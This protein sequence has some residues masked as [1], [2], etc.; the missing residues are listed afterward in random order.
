MTV[1]FTKDLGWRTGFRQLFRNECGRWWRSPAWWVH[2]L[3]WSVLLNGMTALPLWRRGMAAGVD[4]LGYYTLFAGL[5]PVIVGVIIMQNLTIGERLNGT[6]AWVL[7]KPVAPESFVLAKF[8]GAAVNLSVPMIILPSLLAG[9]QVS[10]AESSMLFSP[11]FFAGIGLLL[12]HLLFYLALTAMLGVFF[13][14]RGPVIIIPL[15]LAFIQQYLIRGIPFLGELLP[16]YLAMPHEE[17]GRSLSETLM[18][19]GELYS[20]KAV[21]STAVL[22][23]VF[24]GLAAE[25]LKHREL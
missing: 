4:P 8:A 5:F 6:A 21:T 12:L 9:V 20:Y 25:R 11:S 1:E 2:L 19:G 15:G 24:I 7:S 13:S 18:R 22:I 14:R 16:R 10:L 23:V 17:I 3:L